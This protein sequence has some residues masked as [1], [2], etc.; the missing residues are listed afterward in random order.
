[1]GG[2]PPKKAWGWSNRQVRMCG[3]GEAL[4]IGGICLD[5]QFLDRALRRAGAVR[6]LWTGPVVRAIRKAVPDEARTH[7]QTGPGFRVRS[8]P[9]RICAGTGWPCLCGRN[10]VTVCVL[11]RDAPRLPGRVLH[12]ASLP[13]P[14]MQD[15]GEGAW[16]NDRLAPVQP[17]QPDI[18]TLDLP[19][20]TESRRH[21]ARSCTTLWPGFA[22]A[23]TP[24][25]INNSFG[26]YNLS[27]V[28]LTNR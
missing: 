10:D 5:C 21:L 17:S 2:F 24:L 18:L 7:R 27:A 4:V 25:L 3:A 12:P 8:G 23:L 15:V 26:M 13:S 14:A 1:L 20:N 6:C 28:I 19:E 9:R 11:L 16:H 22:L